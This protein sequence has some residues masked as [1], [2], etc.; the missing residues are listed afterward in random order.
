MIEGYT[1]EEVIKCYAD[2]IKDGKPIGVPSSQHHCRLSGKGTKRVKSIIDAIY[3]RV[4]EAH[5]S[6]MHHLAVMRPYI[7]KH[8]QELHEKN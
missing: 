3:E 2:Y 7:E 4:H 8:L 1:I 6:I 5:F